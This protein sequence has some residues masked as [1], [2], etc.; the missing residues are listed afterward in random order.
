MALPI[1]ERRSPP[2][3]NSSTNGPPPPRTSSFCLLSF[4][5]NYCQRRHALR[6][7]REKI[8]WSSPDLFFHPFSCSSCTL[9]TLSCKYSY[10][11][12]L[13]SCCSCHLS[14]PPTSIAANPELTVIYRQT[15]ISKSP[16]SHPVNQTA[17]QLSIAREDRQGKE[18]IRI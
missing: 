3:P 13:A 1:P 15:I 9:I 16:F 18:T 2:K 14:F 12:C 10:G 17:S 6:R 7:R 4:W 8:D 5:P 11:C